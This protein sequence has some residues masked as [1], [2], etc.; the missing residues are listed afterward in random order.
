MVTPSQK[1]RVAGDEWLRRC[2]RPS[3]RIVDAR[4][5]LPSPPAQRSLRI[6]CA[7]HRSVST[8]G[9]VRHTDEFAAACDKAALLRRILGLQRWTSRQTRAPCRGRREPDLGAV[10]LR[11]VDVVAPVSR[12]RDKAKRVSRRWLPL[13]RPWSIPCA[14]R[15]RK[16][17]SWVRFRS[18]ERASDR[19]P[20][21]LANFRS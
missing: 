21:G 10:D 7:R 17:S 11:P 13:I 15:W 14:D 12:T 6:E 5:H 9:M 3:L 19:G 18:P 1:A 4:S 8:G 16:D 20:L 2:R